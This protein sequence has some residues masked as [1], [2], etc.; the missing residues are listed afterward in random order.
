M[1]RSAL[2]EVLAQQII[3]DDPPQVWRTARRLLDAGMDRLD[4]RRQLLL[5][6]SSSALAG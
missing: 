3:E 4:V 1:P 6:F 2:R 5:A